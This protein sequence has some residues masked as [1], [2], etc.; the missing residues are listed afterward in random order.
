MKCQ[1]MSQSYSL[2]DYGPSAV[3]GGLAVVAMM[4]AVAVAAAAAAAAKEEHHF[5]I[6]RVR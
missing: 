2:T 5:I 1:N 4:V 6:T 3:H